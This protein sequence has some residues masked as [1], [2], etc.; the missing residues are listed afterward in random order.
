[1]RPIRLLHTA[2][3]HLEARFS[4]L[5]AT[6]R[7]Q[8]RLGLRRVFCRLIDKA[9]NSKVNALVISGDLFDN[10]YPT[11]DTVDFVIAEINRLTAKDLPLILIPGNHDFYSDGSIYGQKEFPPNVH[12]FKSNNWEPLE[13]NDEITFLGIACHEFSSERNVLAELNSNLSGTGPVIAILHGSLDYGFYGSEQCYPFSAKDLTTSKADYLALGHYHNSI[14]NPDGNKALYPG[15]PEGLKFTENGERHAFLVEISAGRVKV[16]SVLVNRYQYEEAEID[17]TMF[18]SVRE[19][20]EIIGDMAGADKLV[21]V[22]LV[23]APL[24]EFDADVAGEEFAERFFFLDI[25]NKLALPDDLVIDNENTV[26]SLF[27]KRM[28]GLLQEADGPE[29]RRELELAVRLGVAALDGRL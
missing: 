29:K 18:E 2:D 22:K 14:L 28:A 11:K 24:L 25:I 15:S 9:L 19:L 6:K 8:R 12:I 1:M 16:E 17:C 26:K 3:I 21:R 10:P 20:K 7:K 5:P 4:T 13:L 23:G 27:L